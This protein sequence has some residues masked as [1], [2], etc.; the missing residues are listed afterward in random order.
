MP[1]IVTESKGRQQP[2]VADLA[3]VSSSGCCEPGCCEPGDWYP[4][5]CEPGC[6]MSATE[7]V[8][9]AHKRN[10][11]PMAAVVSGGATRELE[12]RVF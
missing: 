1:T 12:R 2:R 5:C 3:L 6:C 4:G 9:H 10:A 11:V 7:Q 8:A